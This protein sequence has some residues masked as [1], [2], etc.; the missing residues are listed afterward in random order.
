MGPEYGELTSSTNVGSLQVIDG[1]KLILPSEKIQ[2]K[3]AVLIKMVST[4]Q[5]TGEETESSRL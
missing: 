3:A 4:L 2:A 1:A 5:S